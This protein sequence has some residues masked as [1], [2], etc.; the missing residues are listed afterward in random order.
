M[1][2]GKQARSTVEAEFPFL[3]LSASGSLAKA[4]NLSSSHI[5]GR[6]LSR[7][8]SVS[9]G[10]CEV[11]RMVEEAKEGGRSVSWRVGDLLLHLELGMSKGE[12]FLVAIPCGEVVELYCSHTPTFLHK[13]QEKPLFEAARCK[14]NGELDVHLEST[15]PLDNDCV[16]RSSVHLLDYNEQLDDQ[17]DQRANRSRVNV[18]DDECFH[19]KN[20]EGKSDDIQREFEL[21]IQHDMSEDEDGML[22]GFEE[23]FGLADEASYSAEVSRASKHEGELFG[24]LLLL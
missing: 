15:I 9:G 14:K 1:S 7:V 10:V 23:F 21:C 5:V 20:S 17:L 8:A 12:M 2:S 18:R 11:A 19:C 24:E 16:K 4:L 22:D 3:V 6:A 13:V